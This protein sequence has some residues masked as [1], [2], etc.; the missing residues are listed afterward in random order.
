M[1]ECLKIDSFGY[2]L[3]IT[4]LQNFNLT[5]YYLPAHLICHSC[6]S[7]LIQKGIKVYFCDKLLLT[8][9]IIV[10]TKTQ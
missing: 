4:K 3:K 9:N 5:T 10:A 8:K 7:G 2:Y 6:N 1:S